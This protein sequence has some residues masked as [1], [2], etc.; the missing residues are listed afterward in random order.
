MLLLT[1]PFCGP[2]PETEFRC[3]GQAH[4][5]RPLDPNA[6]D[7][8]AWCEYLF[9]RSNTKGIHAER[10]VHVHGCGRWFN[11]LRHTIT[12]AVAATYRM[13]EARPDLPPAREPSR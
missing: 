2:G 13:G 10:W 1:C 4:I 7:D 6:L 9:Y 3:G 12:D 5:V 11:V 8:Q